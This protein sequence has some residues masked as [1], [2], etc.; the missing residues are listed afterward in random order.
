VKELSPLEKERLQYQPDLPA[1][2]KQLLDCNL[3]VMDQPLEDLKDVTKLFPKTHGQPFLKVL[4]SAKGNNKVKSPLKVGVVLSG[5]QAPGGH[6][7]IAGLFDG[8]KKFHPES[9][10][11]GFLSG[12]SGIVNAS[13]CELTA[14]LIA[15]YR[16]LGGF[17][18]IGSGRTKIESEE[19]FQKACQ[20][21]KQL[22]LDGL[23]VIGG[24]DSNTNAALLAEYFTNAKIKTKV[25]GVPKTID[26]DLKSK[27]VESSFGFDTACKTY[28]EVIGN[29]AR[30]ALSARKYY[31]FIKMMGR[32]ASHVTLECAL[33]THPNL[34][35]IAEEVAAEKRTLNAIRD[36]IV[37][38][39]VKRAENGKN[40][41][42]VLIPEGLIEFIPDFKELIAS[43]NHLLL[44]GSA[45]QKAVEKLDGN[46]KKLQAVKAALSEP[47]KERF[48][49]LP[50]DI[51]LQMLLDR[52]PH[53]NV[54][55]S[56]IETE[57]LFISLVSK[58]LKKRQKE[59]RFI[60]KFAAQPHFCGYEGRSCL[61]SDFDAT[62][63]Y[64]L[65]TVAS[66][67]I[68]HEKT[69]YM[70][71]LK[72]LKEDTSKWQPIALPILQMMHLEERHGAIKPV[73]AKA[74]VDLQGPAFKAF[75]E[76]RSKWAEEDAYLYP[77][78]IQFFGKKEITHSVSQTLKLES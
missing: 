65:G 69:G 26:G 57:R 14:P 33:S 25:I 48:D 28:S 53:G 44:E 15:S 70:A 47:L 56:K 17:D 78:P 45:L 41:G 37:D 12:P 36:E 2:L 35:F 51:A 59:G 6:N 54:Q 43:L 77:G 31:Y 13:Y 38:M 22:L 66:L 62:Y 30:D 68:R 19:Q 32:S 60:G 46:E 49:A 42:V 71:A 27:W 63:C 61:P 29:I 39:V 8:L 73:I 7:V 40:Y 34:A 10:L 67:L 4:A 1:L 24:D 72:H 52:D 11:F 76:S 58:E 64:A 23:V 9:R 74:L 75:K 55:V 18:M 5:G 50:E 21:C 16:N 20:T 3:E